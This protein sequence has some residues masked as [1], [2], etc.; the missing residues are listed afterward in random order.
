MGGLATSENTDV[1]ISNNRTPLHVASQEG[2]RSI[3]EY[4]ITSNADINAVDNVSCIF[5]FYP[6]NDNVY[7]LGTGNSFTL[8]CI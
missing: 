8:C 5:C 3:V 1:A 2:H 7:Y 4:L 6:H